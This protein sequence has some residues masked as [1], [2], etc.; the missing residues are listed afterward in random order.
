M[1]KSNTL[2][3]GRLYFD[4]ILKQ[5]KYI[6]ENINEHTFKYEF[7]VEIKGNKSTV[8]LSKFE[9]QTLMTLNEI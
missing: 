9:I 8:L 6:G 1:L 7:E 3:L 5:L 2:I 4:S